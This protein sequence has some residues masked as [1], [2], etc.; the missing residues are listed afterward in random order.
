MKVGASADPSKFG[1]KVLLFYKQNSQL[2]IYPVNPKSDSIEGFKA[3]KH[4]KELSDPQHTSVSVITPPAITLSVLKTAAE[5]GVK[6]IWLQPGSE[7]SEG[8]EF[9]KQAGLN[10]A[11]RKST[12]KKEPVKEVKEVKKE[13][14]KQSALQ[15][16]YLIAY[17]LAS[18]IAWFSVLVVVFHATV[19][20]VRADPTPTMIQVA[21]RLLL[22][23]FILDKYDYPSVRESYFVS[24][25]VIAWSITE[26]VRYGYYALNLIYGT[27]PLFSTYIRYTFFFVLYPV[28]AA[29]EF[30]LIQYAIPFAQQTQPL[31]GFVF[32]FI[33]G[34]YGPGFWFMYQ[35]M[36]K[37]R[38]KV[39]EKVFGKDKTE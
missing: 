21:S 34:M 17:N 36:I 8:I 39:F 31:Y 10:M 27:A 3:I 1:N 32:T 23:W 33:A 16:N 22:V 35:H 38:S 26:I 2:P 6:N 9:A 37:Q 30:M 11:P 7:H 12:T 20:L 5:L 13:V 4:L 28:G 24:S 14:K 15:K 18:C 25:M 19:G 29:S